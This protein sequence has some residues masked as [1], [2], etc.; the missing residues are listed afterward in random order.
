AGAP[1]AL[2]ATPLAASLPPGSYVVTLAAPGRATVRWPFVL[3][4]G[5][6]LSPA[7]TLPPAR[8][9]PDGFVYVPPGRFL[10]GTA[11]DEMRN[12]D[13]SAP[14]HPRTTGGYLIARRETTFGEWLDF[15]AALPP[16]ERARHTPRGAGNLHGA[17]R[18]DAVDGGGWRLVIKP[19]EHAYQA[20]LGEPIVYRGRTHLAAQDWRQFPVVGID[21]TDVEAYTAWLRS[22]GRV[23]GARP[24]R[25]D[26]WER[27]ARGADDREFPHGDTLAPDD[28]N[29]DETYGK[30]PLAF[31]PDAVG[32]HPKSR[33]PFDLDDASGNVWEWTRPLKDA[34]D[35]RVLRGGAYYYATSTNRIPNRQVVER[36]MRDSTLGVRICAEAP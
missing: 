33:S 19:S 29:F 18:L 25:E 11:V 26:E 22:S 15:L 28:A 20:R 17:V 30:E 5:E 12:F 9:V 13:A 32:A 23:P 34:G 31:G 16:A 27:A 21:W 6:S 7:L 8:A 4:R 10:F 24:C 2:G 3:A 35:A 36:G 1:R 14:L